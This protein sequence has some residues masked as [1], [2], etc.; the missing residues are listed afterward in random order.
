MTRK[1]N[2]DNP[3]YQNG[4]GGKK[5]KADTPKGKKPNKRISWHA[6]KREPLDKDE[7][8][9]LLY[10]GARS[11]AKKRELSFNLS[12]GDVRRRVEAG[13]CEVTGIPFDFVRK[14][15]KGIDFPFR[16]S[17]DRIDN[18]VGYVASNVQVVVKIYNHCKWNWHEA[19]GLRLARALVA[20]YGMEDEPPPFAGGAAM[21]APKAL[22]ND[23][24]EHREVA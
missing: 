14:P 6:Q 13:V 4:K 19:D 8:A 12:Y 17:L 21:W 7:L 9:W 15:H 22:L 23:D 10:N 2:D 11:K 16:A 20:R 18:T 5:K 24:D 1:S 3:P